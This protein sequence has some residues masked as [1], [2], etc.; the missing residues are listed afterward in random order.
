MNSAQIRNLSDSDLI[1]KTRS[2]ARSEREITV[3][4][5]HHLR[6]IERRKAYSALGIKNLHE[7]CE[8]YLGYSNGAAHRR[9]DAMKLLKELPE[10]EEKILEGKLNFSTIVQVQTFVRK[11]NKVTDEP[12]S[13]QEKKEILTTLEGKSRRQVDREL[14]KRSVQPEVHFQEKVRAVTQTHTELKVVVPEEA[15]QD[16][17][18]IRGYLAHSHPNMSMSELIVYLAKLG[19]EKL[20]PAKEPERKKK[21]PAP[22][23]PPVEFAGREFRGSAAAV[24]NAPSEHLTLSSG[25]KFANSSSRY[26][27]S[28]LR[29][30]IFQRDQGKCQNCGSKHALQLDH[31]RPY[32]QGGPTTLENLRIL[33]RN[34]NRRHAI[35]KFGLRKIEK[36]G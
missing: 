35:E 22:Q 21:D 30:Q 32:A 36:F 16:L 23:I 28:P 33:C 2:L 25:D 11:E 6:E 14:M 26:I 12:I 4:I 15:I 17:E 34:C 7:Y 13:S 18:V 5:L 1:E 8:N 10:M 9:I 29:R 3:S 20:N 24:L 31:I 27:P 19:K